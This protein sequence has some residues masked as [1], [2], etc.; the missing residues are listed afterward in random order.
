MDKQQRRVKIIAELE[1]LK[2]RS[3]GLKRALG[4]IADTEAD[5][6]MRLAVDYQP[7]GL[8]PDNGRQT[9]SAPKESGSWWLGRHGR[10]WGEG[11]GG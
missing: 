11:Q 9:A 10:E 2:A 3:E 6:A 7:A 8:R 4:V 1:Q 5:E